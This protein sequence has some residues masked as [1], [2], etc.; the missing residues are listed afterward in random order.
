MP[1]RRFGGSDGQSRRLAPR[2]EVDARVGT[3]RATG[4]SVGVVGP[5]DLVGDAH[6]L[7]VPRTVSSHKGSEDEVLHGG[8]V[9]SL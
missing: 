1:E 6:E 3:G 2:P 8:S 7:G 5:G 4:T 9:T